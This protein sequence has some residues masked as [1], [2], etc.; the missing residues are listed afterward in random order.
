MD[1]HPVCRRVVRVHGVNTRVCKYCKIDQPI[2]NYYERAGY[3]GGRIPKCK[4]CRAADYQENKHARLLRRKELYYANQ[5]KNQ[6]YSRNWYA[7]NK[8]RAAAANNAW[9]ARNK[10]LAARIKAAWKARNVGHAKAAA[11]QRRSSVRRATPQWLSASDRANI[12]GFYEMSARVSACLGI[13]HHVDHV[14]PL[15]GKES[16]GLHVPWNLR[17]IPAALNLRKGNKMLTVQ[18]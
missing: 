5:A 15:R 17:V 9:V 8:G 2:T 13:K 7:S 18:A 4:A 10:E 14:Y 1:V 12:A 11:A 6:E 16:C 3:S